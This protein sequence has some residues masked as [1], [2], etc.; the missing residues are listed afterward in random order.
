MTQSTPFLPAPYLRE[1]ADSS[2]PL[3]ISL[4]NDFAFKKTNGGLL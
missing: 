2:R 4:V 1:L 3:N